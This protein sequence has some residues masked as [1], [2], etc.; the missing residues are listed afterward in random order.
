MQNATP[1]GLVKRFITR[2]FAGTT[3]LLP[4][5]RS[6]ITDI[7]GKRYRIASDDDYVSNLGAHFE[8]SMV[9]LF[10][11]LIE[12]HH[13]VLDIGANIGCTTLLFAD[14]ARQIYSFEPSPSTF[15]FLEKNIATAGAENI[16]ATNI[17]LGKTAGTFELT[18]SPNN[19]SGAFVSNQLQASDGHQ[20]ESIR[21]AQGDEYIRN[22]SIPKIDFIKID[23]EGFEKDVIE[24]LARTLLRDMP[25]VVLELNHWCLNAFQRISVP[26]FF[27]FLRNTFPYLYAIDADDAKNIHDRN[28]SYHVMY[29]HIVGGFKYPNL[30]G[31]F[32]KDQLRRFAEFYRVSL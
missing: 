8:P 12:R 26:D 5:E 21:I 24:G 27:D 15:R 1:Q 28:E 23:V 19:R 7:G 31:A 4:N 10:D 17:G 18:F 20:V 9:A 22:A 2:S 29:H 25:T 32:S 11:A 14:R 16:V 13:T 30:V 3:D 6:V